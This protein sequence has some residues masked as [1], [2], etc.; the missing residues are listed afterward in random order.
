MASIDTPTYTPHRAV[1]F[2]PTSPTHANRLVDGTV[3]S[4][5]D[6]TGNAGF[7]PV[8]HLWSTQAID[9]QGQS[10]SNTGTGTG[11]NTTPLQLLD[12]QRSSSTIPTDK[13]NMS[14]DEKP[15]R[16][17]IEP[18]RTGWA[19][20][21]DLIRRYDQRRIHDAKED[22]DTLL[23]FAGLFSAVVTT[24]IVESYRS[25]Q[26]QPEDTTN[27]LLL[28]ISS[29]LAT[30]SNSSK[31]N[32]IDISLPV[33]VPFK[34]STSSV[35]TNT[36]WT[37]SLVIALITASLGILVKQWFHE[38]MAY[39][40][41]DSRLQIA[42]RFFRNQGMKD[43]MVF[44]LAASLPLLLQTAL[45]LFFIGLSAFLRE[46]NPVVGWVTTGIM[47][48]WITIFLF[49]TLAPA[50]SS[51]C[52]YKTPMLKGVLRKIRLWSWLPPLVA[53]LKDAA[54]FFIPSNWRRF[55]VMSMNLDRRVDNWVDVL[56]ADEEDEM[57][58]APSLDM[59]ILVC[60]KDLLRGEHLDETITRCLQGC[61]VK[62]VT[63][64]IT[65]IRNRCGPVDLGFLP[66][67][68][69][70]TKKGV[71]QMLLNMVIENQH[72]IM[73]PDRVHLPSVS[74]PLHSNLTYALSILYDPEKHDFVISER[75]FLMFLRL[76]QEGRTSAAFTILT[77]YRV[78]DHAINKYPDCPHP[79]CSVSDSSIPKLH[80]FTSD[81]FLS[82]LIS[83]ARTLIHVL[84]SRRQPTDNGD[85]VLCLTRTRLFS[86]THFS[87]DPVVFT[88]VFVE[89]CS[90]ARGAAIQEHAGSLVG[91]IDELTDI[92]PVHDGTPWTE[93][94]QWCVFMALRAA[95]AHNLPNESL[96]S[97]LRALPH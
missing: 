91:V 92:I 40:T 85:I 15:L 86:D 38:F 26:Q 44:E 97:R 73:Q 96:V 90:L 77:L 68:A 29:Q 59:S 17:Q 6:N 41:H 36:L 89:L 8:D 83:A 64:C 45:V 11:D 24:F 1:G 43:W 2:I 63:K 71:C 74:P 19:R 14:S 32:D 35:V 88:F 3:G 81:A 95:Q 33:I 70:G 72:P 94:R 69:G 87:L 65:D 13:M 60:S 5:I 4:S 28:R 23:V 50:F 18:E 76:V 75:T 39:D 57:C 51:Q 82:N 58:K 42:T 25:L 54:L 22:I 46:L 16:V 7:S 61:D 93:S 56:K 31:V 48:V 84:W 47:L 78:M 10:E 30:I 52:P 20:L 80:A 37:A 66:D 21:S 49:T 55:R 62:D 79:L 53:N 34:A 27:Q 9:S 12:R 67:T